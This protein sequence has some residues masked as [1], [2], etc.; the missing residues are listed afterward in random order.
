MDAEWSSAAAPNAAIELASC[1]DTTIF[2]GFIALENILSNG[3]AVPGVVSISYHESEPLLGAAE[4]SYIKG[5]YQLAVTGGV[6]VFVAAGDAG[7]ASSDEDQGN[8]AAYDGINVN[9][10]AS[11]PYNVAVG[12]TDFGDT[13]ANAP[14]GTYWSLTNNSD[15][16]SALSYIPEIPWNSTCA[17][18]ADRRIPFC[19]SRSR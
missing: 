6:S 19:Q 4:N 8:N 14:A 13:Y 11:T 17:S 7:A 5:L 15:Y 9:G 12:G 16:G 1:A 3:G 2:G 10:Y 18:R